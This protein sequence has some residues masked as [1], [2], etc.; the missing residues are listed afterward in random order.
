MDQFSGNGTSSKS[1][2]SLSGGVIAG[3]AVVGA[4]LLAVLALYALGVFAQRKAR[5]E[6]QKS[7][8]ETIPAGL[9]WSAISYSLAKKFRPGSSQFLR[10]QKS[11]KVTNPHSRSGLASQEKGINYTQS[12]SHSDNSKLILDNISGKLQYGGL[13][14][15]LGPS[16]A[17]KS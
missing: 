7:P 11:A 15:I 9:E 12:L 10:R 5:R 3:L 13:M 16:G 1:S 14:A 17:G 8:E 4:I 2:S 6:G